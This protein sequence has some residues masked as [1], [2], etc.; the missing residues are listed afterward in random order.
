M[1]RAVLARRA[2]LWLVLAEVALLAVLLAWKRLDGLDLEIYRLGADTFLSGRDLYGPLP[3][4]RDGTLLPFLY[5][6][7]AALA[8]APLLVVPLDVALVAVTLLSALGLGV[9]LALCLGRER[10]GLA[11]GGTVTLAAQAL[12]LLSEPVRATLGFGQ[13]NLLLML[14]VGVDTL[15]PGRYR[16]RGALVGVAAAVKLTPAAFALFFLLRRDFRSV[17]NAGAAFVVCTA[18]GWLLSPET[19]VRFWTDIVFGGQ[20]DAHGYIANQSLRGLLVRLDAPTWVWPL[21]V[22]AALVATVVVMR[23]A[24][25]ARQ[26][27]VAVVACALGGL[28]VSPLSWTHHWVWS[29]PAIGLLCLLALRQRR[30][31]AILLLG[32]AAVLAWVFL[33]GPMWEHRDAFLLR[34]SYVLAGG[35]LLAL[36]AEALRDPLDAARQR[37]DVVRLDGGE[38]ADP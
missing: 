7:F 27:A 11:V 26:P 17:V 19:S 38:H 25:A 36:L 37:A 15:A 14:L 24:L 3:P 29:G 22:V 33:D 23:R 28:L 8:F 9:V 30:A 12:A 10:H 4:T 2:L 6:P 20:I 13:V 35:L 16:W 34:E 18:A 21:A 32:L 1:L 31:R 5:P